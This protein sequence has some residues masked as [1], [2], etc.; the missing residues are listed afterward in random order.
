MYMYSEDVGTTLDVHIQLDVG[1]TLYVHAQL[2]CG[3]NS[4]CACIV[5][6]WAQLFMYMYSWDVGTT[7]YVHVQL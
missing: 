3:H 7:L 1:T 4:L 6:M 2:G 5:R